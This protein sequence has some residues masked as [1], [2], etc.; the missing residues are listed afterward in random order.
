[1]TVPDS[2]SVLVSNTETK[3]LLAEDDLTSQ[4]V[5]VARLTKRGFDLTVADNGKIACERLLEEDYDVVL[6]DVSMPIMDGFEATQIIRSSNAENSGIPI[7]GL[8]AHDHDE[9]RIRCMDCGMNEVISKPAHADKI[10]QTIKN[11]L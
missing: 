5:T 7:I 6:M 8:T 10:C 1:M 2:S 3:V 4:F 9:V 11:W